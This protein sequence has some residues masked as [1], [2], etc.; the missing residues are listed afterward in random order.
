M[1]AHDS[2]PKWVVGFAAE[3][4]EVLAHAQAKLVRKKADVILANHGPSAFGQD[5][6]Q[7]CWVDAQGTGD[8]QS[9]SK[10]SLARW[11]MER[12]AQR[13]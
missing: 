7:I 5:E 6:N 10:L 1:A 12:I 8:W 13:L 11:V 2:R 3:T 9:G 4:Q